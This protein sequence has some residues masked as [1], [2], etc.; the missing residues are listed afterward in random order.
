MVAGAH[1]QDRDSAG[2][3]GGADSG[4]PDRVGEPGRRVVDDL[5]AE[6]RPGVPGGAEAGVEQ[7]DAGGVE[8]GEHECGGRVEVCVQP[9]R[10]QERE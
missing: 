6:V 5:C 1:A 3:A 10:H 7:R 9:G 8:L 4:D 2:E